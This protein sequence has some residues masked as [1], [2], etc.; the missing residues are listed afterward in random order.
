MEVKHE[1]KDRKINRRELPLEDAFTLKIHTVHIPSSPPSFIAGK[2]VGKN[3]EWGGE[4]MMKGVEL[5]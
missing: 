4:R 3:R 5:K 1:G 2:S